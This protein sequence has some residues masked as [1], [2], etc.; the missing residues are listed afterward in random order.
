L[1]RAKIRDAAKG[2]KTVFE[3]FPNLFRL[4]SV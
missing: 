4:L 3:Y 2:A 1:R